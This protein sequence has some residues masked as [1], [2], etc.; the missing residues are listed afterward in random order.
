MLM[1][2]LLHLKIPS[3]SE[4]RKLYFS[5]PGYVGGMLN[6]K[7]YTT[8]LQ[9]IADSYGALFKDETMY[10]L[11]E[12]ESKCSK[13]VPMKK[14]CCRGWALGIICSTSIFKIK[15][16]QEPG[17]VLMVRARS[18]KREPGNNFV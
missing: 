11:K 16:Y 4:F 15:R 12:K 14:L 1:I 5:D 17:P 8:T 3:W 9:P 10:V 13:L 6:L 18:G 2:V 7:R